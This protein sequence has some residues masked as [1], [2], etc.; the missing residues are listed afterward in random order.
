M[1]RTIAA[2]LFVSLLLGSA[3]AQEHKHESADTAKKTEEKAPPAKLQPPASWKVRTDKA[4]GAGKT[5]LAY[6][7]MP[8]GWHITT[9]SQ[10]AIFYDP[11]NT[12]KGEYTVEAEIHVFPMEHNREGYGVF[13]GGSD[14]AGPGQKYVYFLLRGSGEFMVKR[15]SGD[16]TETVNDW[17][18]NAA[19]LPAPAKDPVKNTIVIHVGKD[20][21][22]L[23][24]NGVK[25]ASFP[26]KDVDCDGIF[27]LRINHGINVHV[28][29]LKLSK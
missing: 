21:V 8:P 20:A 18:P 11:A 4:L 22:D 25:L 27:G 14:L 29:S 2:S 13:L 26:R 5:P 16:A 12:A 3:V 1:R 7:A 15:R 17:T 6:V 9:N 28:S 19:I 10:A 23:S 24:A